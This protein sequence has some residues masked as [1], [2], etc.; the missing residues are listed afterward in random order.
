MENGVNV[1][2]P[3]QRGPCRAGQTAERVFEILGTRKVALGIPSKAAA[4]DVADIATIRHDRFHV[5]GR[6][7]LTMQLYARVYSFLEKNVGATVT[8]DANRIRACLPNITYEHATLI[9][10][11]EGEEWSGMFDDTELPFAVVNTPGWMTAP[12]VTALAKAFGVSSTVEIRKWIKT[13][14][15]N[16]EGLKDLIDQVDPEGVILTAYAIPA[17]LGTAARDHLSARLRAA[18]VERVFGG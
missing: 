17:A 7:A 3:I 1:I 14:K 10:E 11:H 16:P 15:F 6:C 18:A 5:L 8:C 12:Q 4:M 2:V 13:H 9:E